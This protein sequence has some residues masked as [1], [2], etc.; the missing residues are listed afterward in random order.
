MD[1]DGI[2]DYAVINRDAVRQVRILEVCSARDDRI[3]WSTE[4][5]YSGYFGYALVGDFNLDG[6]GK[7]DVM[8]SDTRVQ[9]GGAIYAYSNN[10]TLLYTVLGTQKMLLGI[11]LAKVG[12]ADGDGRDDF[13]AGAYDVDDLGRAL[14]I[15]GATGRIIHTGRGELPGDYTG[16]SLTGCGD[17]DGDGVPDFASGGDD[18][19]SAR[20]AVRLFSGRTGE[21]IDT[22]TGPGLRNGFG[23]AL[24]GGNDFDQDGVP[25]L[26]VGAVGI[27]SIFVISGRDRSVLY[28]E[29]GTYQ[30]GRDVAALKPQPGGPFPFF[31]L[32]NGGYYVNP[33]S[34]GQMRCFRGAPKGVQVFGAPFRGTEPKFPKIG[35]RDL[36]PNGV[37]IH[38][39][40]APPGRPAALLIGFSQMTWIGQ[41]LPLALYPFGFPD[42]SMLYTS[43]E[44]MIG[45][46]T[47]TNG[48]AKGYAFVDL[49][50]RPT[51]PG[52]VT[53]HAQWLCFDASNRPAAFSQAISW[54][55]Y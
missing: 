48:I 20:G 49:P 16:Y 44:T 37:R 9:P 29:R 31:F 22:V 43:V 34:Y 25:D 52:L 23:A 38:L 14:L 21:V 39:S 28:S 41:P 46:T 11:S 35:L 5:P 42:G 17:L 1:G 47:G 53:V 40:G 10:G 18:F 33:G 24:A 12:D 7:P 32:P 8:V 45:V 36:G 19:F 2:A 55:V 27:F 4:R 13:V 51:S 15:S 50:L 3:L 6:D 30:L 26:V 54:R